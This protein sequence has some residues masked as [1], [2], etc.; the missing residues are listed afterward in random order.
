M[1]LLVND[2]LQRAI[3][4]APSSGAD[5]KQSRVASGGRVWKLR[6]LKQ[7]RCQLH[8][9]VPRIYA[10]GQLLFGKRCGAVFIWRKKVELC[11]TIEAGV[12]PAIWLF[13]RFEMGEH[14]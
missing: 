10:S 13:D 8:A 14:R 6:T 3:A 12:V 7:E 1:D 5:A 9:I 11:L 4:L 2:Q